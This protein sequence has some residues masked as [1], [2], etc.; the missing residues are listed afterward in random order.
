[1]NE[2]MKSIFE[3]N[4]RIKE[5]AKRLKIFFPAPPHIKEEIKKNIETSMILIKENEKQALWCLTPKEIYIVGKVFGRLEAI[6]SLVA[7]EVMDVREEE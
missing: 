6:Y 1:M 4:E 3:I 5:M 2:K 7:K